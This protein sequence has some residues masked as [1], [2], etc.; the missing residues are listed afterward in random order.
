MKKTIIIALFI[1][2]SPIAQSS[3]VI[4]KSGQLELIQE[5][6]IPSADYE[7]GL[8]SKSIG[9]KL[10]K[11][12]N[13]IAFMIGNAFGVIIENLEPGSKI[14]ATWSYPKEDS[15]GEYSYPERPSE[16]RHFVYWV[17][18]EGELAGNYSLALSINNHIFKTINFNVE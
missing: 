11:E 3:E 10:I 9:A 6:D 12:T 7:S 2:L 8:V 5:F 18:D 14:N 13:N 15:V 4:F 17:L 1:L 16:D